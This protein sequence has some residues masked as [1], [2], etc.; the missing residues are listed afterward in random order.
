MTSQA[1]ASSSAA[2]WLQSLL[3]TG[4]SSQTGR[5][6]NSASSISTVSPTDIASISAQAFQLNQAAG[7]SSS[8]V[9]NIAPAGISEFHKS[10]ESH[11]PSSVSDRDRA[12]D[13]RQLGSKLSLIC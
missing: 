12:P 1:V 2:Q 4:A 9:K 3:A 13:A 5:P 7:I 10:V 8:V 11:A 6:S